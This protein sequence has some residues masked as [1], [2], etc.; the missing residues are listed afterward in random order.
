MRFS[1]FGKIWF[2]LS[3]GVLGVAYGLAADA[4]GWFPSSLAQKAWKQ[5]HAVFP[6]SEP[7]FLNE[8]VYGRSGTRVLRKNEMQPGL[9]LVTSSWKTSDGWR[10]GLRLIGRN[11]KVY[12]EWLLDRTELFDN[13]LGYRKDPKQTDFHGTYLFPNGD[14][15]VNL[16]YV[17]MA[18][19]NPCGKVQWTLSEGTHHS[20]MRASDGTF[21]TPGVSQRTRRGSERF[22]DGFPGLGD[23]LWVDR[24]LQVSSDGSLLR[25][26]N[27]LNVL[28]ANGLEY[29]FFKYR[30]LNG[31]ITHLN[32]VEPLQ[33][34]IAKEYSLF[35][36][37][38][39]LVS[40]RYLNL[41]FVMNPDTKKIKW[42]TTD[43]FIAQHDPDFIGD[44]WIGIFD[45]NRD[46]NNGRV[47]G[48]S[49]IVTVRP[50]DGIRKVRFPKEQSEPFYTS[51]R[52]K[53][54][55]LA[56]G[57]LLL[58]ESQAGRV[59]EVNSD[60]ETVWEWVHQT[61]GNSR[62]PAVTK[63]RRYPLTPSHVASWPCTSVDSTRPH[64]RKDESH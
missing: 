8:R 12:H 10:V 58:T 15:L 21:W 39:L 49:R 44:G 36:Q 4:R 3:V 61:H 2:V 64:K 55:Q 43:P 31:D 1:S 7:P 37:G 45:N 50:Q 19:I 25:D 42:F 38:D 56:N 27:V 41:V 47:L 28:Y 54:Q 35:E 40:L 63:A 52:G 29:L 48:G 24:I 26:I 6:I 33:K 9:T 32:D 59:V 62:V 22:P 20:I 5:G 60:G 18:R 30:V 23:E 34:S 51:L 16:E 17:G 46:Y 53:W 14:V 13:D 57:N 11:G